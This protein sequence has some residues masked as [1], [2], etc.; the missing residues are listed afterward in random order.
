MCLGSP[1]LSH[2]GKFALANTAAVAKQYK[3]KLITAFVEVCP[4]S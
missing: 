4:G 1:N 2:P 3:L